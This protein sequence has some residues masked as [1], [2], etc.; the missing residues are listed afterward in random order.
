M[1]VYIYVHV[2]VNVSVSQH[3]TGVHVHARMSPLNLKRV[4]CDA[5]VSCANVHGNVV[6]G[7]GAESDE[8]HVEAAGVPA[9]DTGRRV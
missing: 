7:I 2:H 1:Y 8:F 9:Q 3:A 6:M 5:T 4:I